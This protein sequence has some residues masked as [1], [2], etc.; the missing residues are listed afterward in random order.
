VKKAVNWALRQIRKR[1][2]RLNGEALRLAE[3][4]SKQETRSAKWVATDAI[5]ELSGDAVQKEL[6]RSS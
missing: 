2:V 5:R 6:R 4:I 1:N 3:R